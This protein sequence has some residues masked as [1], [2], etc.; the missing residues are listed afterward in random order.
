MLTTGRIG[1]AWATNYSVTSRVPLHPTFGPPN[2]PYPPSGSTHKTLPRPFSHA[3]YSFLHGGLSPT[4]PN[5]TPF[6]SA[7]NALGS[8]LLKKLQSREQP[9]PHPPNPY[10]GLP[11]DAT[12]AEKELYDANGPLWYRGWAMLDD[13]TVCSQVDAVLDMTGTRRM[14]MGHTPDFTVRPCF[15]QMISLRRTKLFRPNRNKSPVAEVK[16]SSLILVRVS[17]R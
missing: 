13:K 12:S 6:P 2:T 11:H 4:Y 5:L 9:A 17:P 10:P 3:A 8:S 7:I 16:S 1:R 15:I 14:I